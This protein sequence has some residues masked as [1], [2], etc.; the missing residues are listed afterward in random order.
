LRGEDDAVLGL[1]SLCQFDERDIGAVA[2]LSDSAALHPTHIRCIRFSH[3]GKTSTETR[4]LSRSSCRD[5]PCVNSLDENQNDDDA[6]KVLLDK[7][8]VGTGVEQM[9]QT[10]GELLK[11]LRGQRTQRQ[12]AYALGVTPQ[13]VSEWE[14]DKSLPGRASA[15]ALDDLLDAGGQLVA[16]FN[17]AVPDRPVLNLSAVDSPRSSLGSEAVFVALRELR[18][19]LL[20]LESEVRQLRSEVRQSVEAETTSP[21]TPGKR[22]LRRPPKP[23]NNRPPE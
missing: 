15:K 21:P 20:E 4:N 12:I 14:L 17:D 11:E 23:S 3:A 5:R 2:G 9:T 18:E 16:A 10:A 7:R 1:E 22:Q 8:K 13:A 19:V 6:C